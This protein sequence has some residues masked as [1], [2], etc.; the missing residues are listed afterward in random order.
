MFFLL[1]TD[2]EVELNST[3]NIRMAQYRNDLAINGKI[4]LVLTLLCNTDVPGSGCDHNDNRCYADAPFSCG[5]YVWVLGHV[6]HS[7]HVFSSAHYSRRRFSIHGVSNQ[8][9]SSSRKLS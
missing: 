4:L 1:P 3:L 8:V 6:R 5:L 2:D 9:V 7:P